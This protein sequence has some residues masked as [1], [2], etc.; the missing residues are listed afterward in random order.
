MSAFKK[1]KKKRGE[2]IKWII[3]TEEKKTLKKRTQSFSLH[4]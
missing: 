4:H 2:K 3:K 1:I